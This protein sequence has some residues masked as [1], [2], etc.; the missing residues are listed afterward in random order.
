MD[1]SVDLG[2][3]G[4]IEHP[5]MVESIERVLAAAR[6]NGVAVGIISGN[7]E[8]VSKWMRAGMRFVSF[9]TETLLLQEI[10]ATT[11]KRLRSVVGG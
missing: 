1:L 11:V 7:F 9:S 8:V 2:V 4:E 10:S 3:P 6:R 5:S